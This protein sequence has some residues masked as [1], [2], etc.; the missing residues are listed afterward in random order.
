MF[1]FKKCYKKSSYRHYKGKLKAS[2]RMA[3]KVHM[4]NSS[5]YSGVLKV[6]LTS[7]G[8]FCCRL[9]ISLHIPV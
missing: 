2:H 1:V 3:D 7:P 6:K 5:E 4:P 8:Q 9:L